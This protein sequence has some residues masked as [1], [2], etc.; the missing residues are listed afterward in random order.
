VGGLA[1]AFARLIEELG[2]LRDFIDSL[3]ADFDHGMNAKLDSS[4]FLVQNWIILSFS[5]NCSFRE[6]YPA[7]SVV[8]TV[9]T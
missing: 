3:R 4:L 9:T 1:S 6:K 5:G 8:Y 2:V 7:P